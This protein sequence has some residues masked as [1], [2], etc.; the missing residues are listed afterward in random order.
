MRLSSSLLS[1]LSE[2]RWPVLYYAVASVVILT[3][4]SL[5]YAILIKLSRIFEGMGMQGADMGLMGASLAVLGVLALRY[6]S[7]QSFRELERVSGALK[8]HSREMSVLLEKISA[9]RR[10]VSESVSR[11]AVCEVMENVRMLSENV[12]WHKQTKME[13][14]VEPSRN[15]VFKANLS[16]LI[17]YALEVLLEIINNDSGLMKKFALEVV[18]S[19]SDCLAGRNFSGRML[20]KIDLACSNLTA[21]NLS[22]ASLNAANLTGARLDSAD[23][24][25]ASLTAANLTGAKLKGARLV[26][27][28]LVDTKGLTASQLSEVHT[29]Y[30]AKLPP[31]IKRELRQAHPRLF[32]K[33]VYAQ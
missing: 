26:S 11:L 13:Y 17:E 6:S 19:N 10:E 5:Y 20:N 2:D 1:R 4:V 9:D 30:R 3:G 8:L 27:T 14:W 31:A 7:V 15:K 22:S 25:N 33:P 21:A 12:G 28:S 18:S 29:L 24:T 32:D 23:L 16:R